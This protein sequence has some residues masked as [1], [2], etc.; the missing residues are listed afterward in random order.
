MK[1]AKTFGEGW[2]RRSVVSEPRLSEVAAFYGELGLEVRLVPVGSDEERGEDGAGCAVCFEGE[3]GQG[4][5]M[6]VYTRPKTL[7]GDAG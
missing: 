4:A 2:T 1:D 5:H 3:G 6:V 7:A